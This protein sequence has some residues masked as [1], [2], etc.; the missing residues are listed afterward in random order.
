MKWLRPIPCL[1]LLAAACLALTGVQ[2]A[3]AGAG[4]AAPSPPQQ[5]SMPGRSG[6]TGQAKEPVQMHTVESVDLNRYAGFWYEIA[7]IPNRFQTRCARRTIASYRL[8]PDGRISV[9]N[10]CIKA[11][12]NVEQASGVAR[13]VDRKT[14]A[15]LKVSLVSLLG[16]R[17]FWGDYWIL[18]L[19]EGYRWAIVAS[20]DR[21]YGWILSRTPTLEAAS[22]ERIFAILER[23]GL[24]PDRFRMSDPG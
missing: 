9:L 7:R 20:P 23:N 24:Q 1:P 14:R 3:S 12:G 22:L 19:G 10:Q 6:E 5:A 16:W 17:P 13:V 21:Q 15:R 2:Q 11:N 18:G 8:R 4:T